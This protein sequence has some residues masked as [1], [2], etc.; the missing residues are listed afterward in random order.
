MDGDADGCGDR[1][2]ES[3]GEASF[4]D[5]VSPEPVLAAR[6]ARLGL[7]RGQVE[8]S[9]A[10]EWSEKSALRSSF[11]SVIS[12]TPSPAMAISA[13]EGKE[14]T[15][16]NPKMSPCEVG[17]SGGELK[18]DR[19]SVYE[20]PHAVSSFSGSGNPG[21]GGKGKA[22]NGTELSAD[23]SEDEGGSLWRRLEI[24]HGQHCRASAKEKDKAALPRSAELASTDADSDDSIHD[25]C[26]ES[27]HQVLQPQISASASQRE[28]QMPSIS[29]G[30]RIEGRTA[31]EGVTATSGHAAAGARHPRKGATSSQ[32]PTKGDGAI[33][34]RDAGQERADDA[35]KYSE[36]SAAELKKAMSMY[37]FARVFAL[38]QRRP[39][40]I[41]AR[42]DVCT[43][44]SRGQVFGLICCA[45]LVSTR[46]P[47]GT[48]N[49]TLPRAD[50]ASSLGQ[51]RTWCRSSRRFG[52][53]CMLLGR[54]LL[55]QG[56]RAAPRVPSEWPLL[57][58]DARPGNR[59][60]SRS[61][62]RMLRMGKGIMMGLEGERAEG[63]HLQ[64]AASW[65]RGAICWG[66]WML[67]HGPG[68]ARR[69]RVRT[70]AKGRGGESA[71]R[72]AS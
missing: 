69:A 41:G 52:R 46:R 26:F 49:S 61:E 53:P 14:R 51:S 8:C 42:I 37:D 71:R 30:K 23:S 50:T 64:R 35:S 62:A 72:S 48:A 15:C 60:W 65:G 18:R 32:C 17:A 56:L 34:C 33:R 11:G 40:A 70:R 66:V 31:G 57:Q 47:L 27:A 4:V 44:M 21:E 36:M 25:L 39:Q 16:A 59:I 45:C 19:T 68:A 2:K 24:K 6:C 58:G 67:A 7:G 55:A 1:D 38:W 63:G 28:K 9:D 22:V 43:Y 5:L 54:V 3:A 10:L 13:G 20:T 29:G 12:E